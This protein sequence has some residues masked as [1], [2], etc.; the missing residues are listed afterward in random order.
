MNDTPTE[1]VTEPTETVTVA[2]VHAALTGETHQAAIAAEAEIQA[3]DAQDLSLSYLELRAA[4]TAALADH[5]LT[6]FDGMD[7]AATVTVVLEAV[8]A[9]HGARA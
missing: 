9:F 7:P 6:R 5:W 2:E 4:C 3:A 1:T 8:A